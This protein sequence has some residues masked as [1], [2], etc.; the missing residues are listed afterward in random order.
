MLRN[1]SYDEEIYPFVGVVEKF[2]PVTLETSSAL[3]SLEDEKTQTITIDDYSNVYLFSRSTYNEL[4]AVGINSKSID[5]INDY[6]LSISYRG[7][8]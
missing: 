4:D 6:D 7:R 5:L 8:A 3:F 2:N 1:L